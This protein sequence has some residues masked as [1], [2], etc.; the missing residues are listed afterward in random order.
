LLVPLIAMQLTDEVN[1]DAADFII[2]GVILTISGLVLE[3]AARKT[4]NNTFKFAVGMGVLAAFLL[5]WINGAVGIIGNEENPANIPFYGVIFVAF[6][7]AFIA[8]FEASRMEKA[9]YAAAGAQLLVFLVLW[10]GGW[11]FTGPITIFFTAL[12]FGSARLFKQ[13]ASELAQPEG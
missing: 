12:W 4:G 2:F 9:M 11:G 5:F 7:G 13:A 3:L 6:I 10:I 8:R 1:W